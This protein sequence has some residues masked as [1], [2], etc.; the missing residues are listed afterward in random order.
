M[1]N[2]EKNELTPKIKQEIEKT[3]RLIAKEAKKK[4]PDE[5]SKVVLKRI[6]PKT[7]FNRKKE[8]LAYALECAD[9]LEEKELEA[10]EI[11]ESTESLEEKEK[12]L[13]EL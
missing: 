6:L 1:I 13:E 4:Y 3:I 9:R 7:L 11:M 12:R 8:A 10:D 5:N 2:E